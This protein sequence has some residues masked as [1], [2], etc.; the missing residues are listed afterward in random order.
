MNDC[1][2]LITSLIKCKILWKKFIKINWRCF[3]LSSNKE[4]KNTDPDRGTQNEAHLVIKCANCH[5]KTSSSF[6]MILCATTLWHLSASANQLSLNMELVNNDNDKNDKRPIDSAPLVARSP[7][8]YCR[9][10]TCEKLHIHDL[11]PKCQETFAPSSTCSSCQHCDREHIGPN[12]DQLM[13][14]KSLYKELPITTPIRNGPIN[15]FDK[16]RSSNFLMQWPLPEYRPQHS[17][18]HIYRSFEFK[19]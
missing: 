4:E 11:T 17:P 19:K 1:H 18:D 7:S 10:A 13:M 9:V 16:I 3:S 8:N 15:S 12:H 14:V 6:P 2:W 5:R